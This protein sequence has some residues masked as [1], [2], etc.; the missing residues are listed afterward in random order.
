MLLFPSV[1]KKAQ[2]EIDSV[3]GRDQQPDFHDY[4]D[5]PYTRAVV[6]EVQRWRPILPLAVAHSNIYADEYNG[7]YIPPGSTIYANT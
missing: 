4:A 2:E 1:M 5:L 7:M 6:N 3:I